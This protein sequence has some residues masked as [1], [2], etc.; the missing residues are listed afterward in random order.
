MRSGWQ[1]Y[2]GPTWLVAF[3]IYGGWTGLA[4]L[5]RSVPLA[6][7][8]APAVYLTAWHSSLQHET[9]H[10]LR[11]VPRAAKLALALPPLGLWFP[12]Q[13]YRREHERHHATAELA[14]PHD[15]ESFYHDPA[16]WARMWAPLRAAY[17]VNQTLAG[18]L[19]LGPALLIGRVY[20]NEA[21]RLMRGDTGDAGTW[22]LHAALVAALATFLARCGVNPLL[23][24]ALVA[25]PAASL[26]LVRS[27]AEHRFGGSPRE[28][29]VSVESRSLLSLLFLNNNLHATHHAHPSL[30]WYDLPRRYR[31][32]LAPRDGVL[33]LRGYRSVLRSW[34]LRPIDFP[35]APLK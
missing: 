7:A 18:R 25:Y 1:R 13:V 12:Y 19:I 24:A 31:N 8:L 3:A 26:G 10:A 35:V 4:L 14:A 21:R 23:Y 30:L 9:I 5:H 2:E 29:T 27:F 34:L 28:R 20:A 15:P 33:P 16:S 17:V 6:L 32:H 11:R 22:I